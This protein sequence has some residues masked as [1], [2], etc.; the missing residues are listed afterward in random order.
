MTSLRSDLD[1]YLQL[2]RRL[3]HDLADAARLLPRYLDFLEQSGQTTITVTNA[4]TWS[5]KP[6]A[7]PGSSVRS[8]RMTAVRGF[9]RYLSGIDPATEVP[10]LGLVPSR[11][12]WRPPFIYTAE[13]IAMLLTAAAAMP[14]PLRSATYSTLFG[15]LTATGMRVGEALTLDQTDID[16]N[17]GVL[18]IRQSKFGKSRN[19]PVSTS[20]L[21]ALHRYSLLRNSFRPRPGNDSFFVS[22]TGRRL[23]YVSVFEV[24]RDLRES[25][26]L[27]ATSTT[28]PRIHDYADLRVVPTCGERCCWSR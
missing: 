10:P 20:T 7:R 24:F 15:L 26:G 3:G 21:A 14:S 18:L 8:R 12:R 2:R 17:Q 5:Q 22:L 25:T 11:Q 23:I 27:G 6:Q 4:V 28:T 13:D 1:N 16:W 19:V 9:A